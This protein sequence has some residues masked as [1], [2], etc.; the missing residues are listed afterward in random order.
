[1]YLLFLIHPVWVQACPNLWVMSPFFKG[2]EMPMKMFTIP[3]DWQNHENSI[4]LNLLMDQNG[5]KVVM[6]LWFIFSDGLPFYWKSFLFK[7]NKHRQTGFIDISSLIFGQSWTFILSF[8]R[9]QNRRQFLNVLW[10]ARYYFIVSNNLINQKILF[11]CFHFHYSTGRKT[12][13]GITRVLGEHPVPCLFRS[14]TEFTNLRRF[15]HLF[16]N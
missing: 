2:R 12:G 13:A 15:C 9:W 4:F 7:T 14:F 16:N 10:F 11:C 3:V 8:K 1:M 5:D 6:W